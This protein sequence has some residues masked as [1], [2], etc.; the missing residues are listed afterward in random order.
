MNNFH[1]LRSRL[2]HCQTANLLH[3][4]Y[5]K[6]IR[7]HHENIGKHHENIR[8]HHE[9]IRKHHEKNRREFEFLR[10]I[11]TAP[12]GVSTHSLVPNFKEKIRSSFSSDFYE[13]GGFLF[14]K[15]ILIVVLRA[16]RVQN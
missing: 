12:R 3:K 10:L 11:L 6:N 9:N 14:N 16:L 4:L 2:R 15:N 5:A 7:K 8:K 13:F 1:L